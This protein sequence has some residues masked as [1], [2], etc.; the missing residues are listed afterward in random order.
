MYN[1]IVTIIIS[2]PIVTVPLEECTVHTFFSIQLLVVVC[3][4]LL[5]GHPFETLKRALTGK[6]QPVVFC[7]INS[8]EELP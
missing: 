2:S 4:L 8:L 5:V 7:A 6:P 1:K 3:L